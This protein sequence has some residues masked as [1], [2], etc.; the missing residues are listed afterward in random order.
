MFFGVGI[1]NETFYFYPVTNW[2]NIF[3]LP[4]LLS[5]LILFAHDTIPHDHASFKH[6]CTNHSGSHETS[7]LD[8]TAR[9]EKEM[10]HEHCTFSVDILPEVSVDHFFFFIV[11]R[12]RVNPIV[13]KFQKL[14]TYRSL[15][16]EDSAG[17]FLNL[18]RAP[19]RR[20]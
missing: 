4:L 9:I 18:L 2:K 13:Q 17:L 15:L 10:H 14:Y 8:T 6:S 19:P 11:Q 1:L 3:V 12:I 20:S 7:T 5:W 16:L